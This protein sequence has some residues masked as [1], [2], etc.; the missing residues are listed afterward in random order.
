MRAI[1]ILLVCA[2]LAWAQPGRRGRGGP[3]AHAAPLN[4]A[5]VEQGEELYNQSCTMCHGLKGTVG[6]RAPALAANRRY[7]RATDA[8]LFDAIKN[9]IK[10]TLM[11]PTPLP[12]ADIGKLVAYIRSLRASAVDAP[13]NGDLTRGGAV[14]DGKGACRQ[15]HMV[16]GR[17][18]LLGPDLSSL[19]AERSLRYIE[20]ALTRPKA[21][22]PRGYQPVS[23]VDAEG[24]R[25]RA[26][27]K[28]ETNFSLQLLDEAGRLHLLLREEARGLRY[29]EQSLMP[30]D[31]DKR[32]TAGEFQDL[33]AFLSRRARSRGTR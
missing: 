1:A 20:E 11:P 8:A 31:Y 23:F 2:A 4:P 15:C 19:G 5:E 32:L 30:A 17:G 24:R 33:L 16:D 22:I 3:P 12:D 21:H 6:D 13:V 7:L 27:V 25:V 9:G 10:G 18:G 29:E 26:V 14:F 28:N